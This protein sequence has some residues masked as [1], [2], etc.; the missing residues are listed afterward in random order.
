MIS[1]AN[2]D[3]ALTRGADRKNPARPYDYYFRVAASDL[4]QGPFAAGF[5][6]HTAGKR[7]VAV[8][9]DTTT[10]GQDLALGFKTQFEKLGGRVPAVETVDTDTGD[11]AAV[12]TRIRRLNPDMVFFGGDYPA[13]ARLR[14]QAV[15]QGVTVPFMGGYAILDPAYVT[16]AKDAAVGDFATSV[17]AATEQLPTA[18][19]FVAAY[20]AAGYVD[21]ADVYGAYAYDAANAVIAALAKVLPGEPRVTDALRPRLRQALQDGALDGATGRVAFDRF[22]DRTTGPLTVYEVRKPSPGAIAWTPKETQQSG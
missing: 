11:F 16:L 21:P 18:R 20:K 4:V 1:P 10:Y 5:A 19:P 2:T 13:A 3:P 15:G 9:H 22:G 8:V 14:S 6:Y 12:L 17:G 7:A